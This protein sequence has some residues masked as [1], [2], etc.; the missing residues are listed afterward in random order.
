[1]VFVSASRRVQGM[2]GW[3]RSCSQV[4]K[5]AALC[6]SVSTAK[7]DFLC[8]ILQVNALATQTAPEA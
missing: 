3:I 5:S 4:L 1:M 7:K 6:S 8:G 2:C